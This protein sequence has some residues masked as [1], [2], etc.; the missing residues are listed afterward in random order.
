MQYFLE[1]KIKFLD[2]FKIVSTLL[3]KQ[4]C[5]SKKNSSIEEVLA[6]DKEFRLKTKEFIQQT[7]KYN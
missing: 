7:F 3:E 6:L 1:K 4:V 2:I 5:T